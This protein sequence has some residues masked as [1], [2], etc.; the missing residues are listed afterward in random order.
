MSPEPAING[1]LKAYGTSADVARDWD[2]GDAARFLHDWAGRFNDHFGL[3]LPTPVIDIEKRRART[4][5]YQP[6]RN[7]L[8][9][10]HALRIDS[11]WL[12]LPPAVVLAVLLRELLQEG[13]AQAGGRVSPRYDDAALRQRAAEFGLTFDRCG[14]L[15][16]VAAGR[17]TELLRRHG[18]ETAVLGGPLEGYFQR[19]GSSRLKK[20][21]CRCTRVWAA[22]AVQAVCTACGQGFR[23]AAP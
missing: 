6:G 18:V 2:H 12:D 17:F 1:A 19:E 13:R 9:L 11:R 16:R 4:P 7:G 22:T 10:Q 5:R 20:W 23:R 15:R 8:G 14:R 3:G 21:P